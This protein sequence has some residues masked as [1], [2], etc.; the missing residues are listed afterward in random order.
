MSNKNN[1]ALKLIEILKKKCS[2]Y[3]DLMTA[4][5]EAEYEAAFDVILKESLAHLEKNKTHYSSLDEEGLT[6]VLAGCLTMPGLIVSQEKHSN[7][8]V[9]ITIEMPYN[10]VSQ[11]KLGEAKIYNGPQYHIDGLKQLLGRYTTGREG[12][13]LL[14]V[15][16]QIKDISGLFNK[17]RQKMDNELPFNQQG[18]AKNCILKWSFITSHAHDC[19][20]NLEVSHV[21]CNM[22]TA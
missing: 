21:G 14:I 18:D 1:S 12:R 13:G 4:R 2:A 20:D 5:N 6:S 8:H 16:V 9:D 3:V 17:L 11:T 10:T 22:Y 19:G 15:Y 7:G